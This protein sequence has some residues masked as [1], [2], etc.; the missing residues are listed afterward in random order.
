MAPWAFYHKCS[1]K[2]LSQFEAFGVVPIGK[3]IVGNSVIVRDS[4]ELWLSG[5]QL[6]PGYLEDESSDRFVKLNGSRWYK[7]GDKVVIHDGLYLCKGRLD[8]QV[9]IGG[10]RIELMDIEAHLRSMDGVDRA[11][12]FV[13]G[14]GVKKSI[15]AALHANREID[16]VEV[17]DHLKNRLPAYMIPRKSFILN[18]LPLNKS[19]KIDRIAIQEDYNNTLSDK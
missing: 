8:S 9:K 10:Y 4:G 5:P 1:V 12:C 13:E 18:E 3:P 16:L 2:D 19:G 15:V 14:G 17:R 11:I 7:T 6:T